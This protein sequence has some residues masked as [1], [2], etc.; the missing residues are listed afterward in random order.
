MK[1]T[2]IQRQQIISTYISGNGDISQ[3]V[4][5]Q[6]YRVSRSTISK[7]LN[8]EEVKKLINE[9]KEQ[10]ILSMLEY[11]E[12]K[13]GEAQSLMSEILVKAGV[14]LKGDNSLRDLMGALK[15]L[16]EVFGKTVES[17]EENK[18][19]HKVVFEIVGVGNGNEQS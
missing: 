19:E 13:Q 3:S 9:K 4:L 6:K 8:S 10:N 7:I 1:I 11:I 5:A 2:E 18:E 17:N 15:I 14:K 12:S 16:A